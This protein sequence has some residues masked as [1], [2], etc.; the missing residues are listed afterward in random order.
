MLAIHQRRAALTPASVY[1]R[2]CTAMATRIAKTAL[3]NRMNV[4]LAPKIAALTPRH[5]AEEAHLHVQVAVC[6][7]SS[8]ATGVTT[9]VIVD[10]APM[11]IRFFVIPG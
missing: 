6:R 7:P 3:M 1:I 10:L 4:R 9:V 11:R 5:R 8:F 2:A